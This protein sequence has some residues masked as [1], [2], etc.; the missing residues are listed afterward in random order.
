M[1]SPV[2]TAV[3]TYIDVFSERDPAKRAAMIDAC[4]AE[5]GRFVTRSRETRG[6]A[7]IAAL[8]T[9]LFADPT[10]TGVRVTA[11]DAQGTTFRFR[12]VIDKRDGT[13]AEFFDA[14]EI[15]ADGRIALI[16]TFSGPF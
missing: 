6:R 4:F 9:Q 10:V 5:N 15:D 1:A 11:L 7:A 12:S 14:G 16:F 2:E 3:A 8:A 13:T